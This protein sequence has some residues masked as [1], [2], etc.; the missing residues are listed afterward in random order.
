MLRFYRRE[1]AHLNRPQV[2]LGI[3]LAKRES[4]SLPLT[5]SAEQMIP[6][7]EFHPSAS[8]ISCNSIPA[9]E[10][11]QVLASKMDRSSVIS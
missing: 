11:I 8:A 10:S 9:Q 5:N 6:P 3:I 1:L 7:F 4:K 2:M